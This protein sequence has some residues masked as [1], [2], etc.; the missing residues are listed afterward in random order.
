MI[1][2]VQYNARNKEDGEQNIT[3]IGL[4]FL[5][6][7]PSLFNMQMMMSE[8]ESQ[9]LKISHETR[10]RLR[11]LFYV[12]PVV[13]WAQQLG[14]QEEYLDV[15]HTL[16]Y[17]LSP[18]VVHGELVERVLRGSVMRRTTFLLESSQHKHAVISGQY[19]AMP[20]DALAVHSRRR[21]NRVPVAEKFESSAT[22]KLQV[23]KEY[24]EEHQL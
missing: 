1:H 6:L 4:Y 23:P 2:L 17:L 7:V 15:K 20:A 18:G 11:A 8:L 22:G 9:E 21:P 5:A 14:L 19:A 16:K 13:Q 24:F 12:L 10:Q 3:H